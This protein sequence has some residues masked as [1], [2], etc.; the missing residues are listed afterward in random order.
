MQQVA[1]SL[2]YNLIEASP[3]GFAICDKRNFDDRYPFA[4]G[5]SFDEICVVIRRRKLG[6][7]GDDNWT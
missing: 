2:G 6:K 1:S 3:S 4:G 7:W 5:V